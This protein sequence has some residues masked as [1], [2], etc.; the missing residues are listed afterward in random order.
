[1]KEDDSVKN[2]YFRGI[3]VSPKEAVILT[4]LG[5]KKSTTVFSQ[6]HRAFFEEGLKT[7]LLLCNSSAAV[8]RLKIERNDGGKIVLENG[9][10]FESTGLSSFLADCGELFLMGGTVGSEITQKISKEIESGNA[11]MGL[12]LDAVASQAADSIMDWAMDF[13][14]KRLLKEGLSLTRLRYSPGYSDLGLENQKKIYDLLKLKNIGI[15]ITEKYML[16]PEKS[17]IAIAGIC[18]TR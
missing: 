18:R 10:V 15:K 8:G 6:E 16:I 3:K 9:T 14:N 12:I 1:M 5:Y 2:E 17:V 7:G 4:R 13:L 11:G